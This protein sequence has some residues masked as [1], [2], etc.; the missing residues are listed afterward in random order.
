M[1]LRLQQAAPSQRAAALTPAAVKGSMAAQLL[2]LPF[3]PHP[4]LAGHEAGSFAHT[5]ISTRLPAIL[6]TVLADLDRLASD[7]AHSGEV[8]GAQIA[9]A[10]AD[11]ARLQADMRS[12]A[13]LPF[14]GPPSPPAPQAALMMHLVSWT[15]NCLEAWSDHATARTWFDL[16]WLVIECYL[17][18]RLA[19]IMWSQVSL[20]ARARCSTPD[21]S[22]GFA[23]LS[24][25]ELN[26]QPRPRPPLPPNRSCCSPPW[27]QPATIPL[28]CR[29]QRRSATAS[30]AWRTSPRQRCL[31]WRR[32][33]QRAPPGPGTACSK[34]YRWRADSAGRLTMQLPPCPRCLSWLCAPHA[35]PTH[36][37]GP[38]SRPTPPPPT[39]TTAPPR[40]V[41]LAVC[42]VGQQDGPVAAGGCRKDW[43]RRRHAGTGGG[44]Q[45]MPAAAGPPLQAAAAV[46]ADMHH[47]CPTA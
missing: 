46:L 19:A 26:P 35:R 41:C 3:P 20:T 6:D 17:Y 32:R 28:R 45:R 34:S 4:P 1:L 37:R 33:Q 40:P 11:V 44:A 14:L 29:K 21:A 38:S 30:P 9:A 12:N 47:G 43:C 36:A 2:Q 25:L 22:F 7:P 13:A 5:T 18:V 10:R 27:Q 8:A 23:Q 31:W 15:N 16:P 39:H 24:I 42:A